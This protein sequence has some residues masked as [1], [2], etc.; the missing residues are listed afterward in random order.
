MLVRRFLSQS[1]ESQPSSFFLLDIV[2]HYSIGCVGSE[3]STLEG[4]S[5][6][7]NICAQHAAVSG[8]TLM[9][10]DRILSQDTRGPAT[11]YRESTMSVEDKTKRVCFHESHQKAIRSH[12][13]VRSLTNVPNSK[14]LRRADTYSPL[15]RSSIKILG[16]FLNADSILTNQ[17]R[18]VA[19]IE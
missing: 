6:G 14:Y 11:R 8:T 2:D 18:Y 10:V 16:R 3:N 1:L 9:H 19:E 5:D 17:V 7:G 13:P 12:H 4:E 15:C